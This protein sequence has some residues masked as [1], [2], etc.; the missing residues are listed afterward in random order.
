MKNEL[1]RKIAKLIDI[2][3]FITLLMTGVMILLLF[4]KD[5]V[6]DE[7][8]MLFSTSYGSIVTYYYS[9]KD[10]EK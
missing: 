6:N 7:L 9:R 10:G 4:Y 3:S 5:D 1:I 2:K 8:L